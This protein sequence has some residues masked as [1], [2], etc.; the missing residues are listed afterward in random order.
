MMLIIA[1]KH[2]PEDFIFRFGEMAEREFLLGCS[3]RQKFFILE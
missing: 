2:E 1:K 3:H